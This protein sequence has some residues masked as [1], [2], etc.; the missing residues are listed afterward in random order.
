MRAKDLEVSVNTLTKDT[1]ALSEVIHSINADIERVRGE[2]KAEINRSYEAD[3]GFKAALEASLKP[4][5]P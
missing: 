1:K 4:K 5:T 3:Q 2:I